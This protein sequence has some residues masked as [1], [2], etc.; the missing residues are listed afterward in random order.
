MRSSYEVLPLF[1]EF[2]SDT[3]KGKRR[4]ANGAPLSIAT[5]KNDETVLRLLQ[6][7]EEAASSK[8]TVRVWKGFNKR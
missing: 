2:I 7:Y 1:E 6:A 5:V 8:L 4:K 3:R